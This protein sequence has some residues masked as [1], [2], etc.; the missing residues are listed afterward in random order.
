MPVMK[1]QFVNIV[2]PQEQFDAFILKH[3]LNHE[4]EVENALSVIEN[5]KGLTP[6]GEFNR[7][8]AIMSR[9]DSLNKTFKTKPHDIDIEKLIEN[10]TGITETAE[11]FAE[12]LEQYID[13]HKKRLDEKKIII[14]KNK[15]IL[16]RMM[17]MLDMEVDLSEL[18]MKFI[19]VRFGRMAYENYKRLNESIKRLN[20]IVYFIKREDDDVWFSYYAPNTVINEV[21]NIFASLYFERIDLSDAIVGTPKETAEILRAEIAVVENEVKEEAKRYEEFVENSIHQ[22]DEIYSYIYFLFKTMDIKKYAAHTEESFYLSG[23]IPK[24]SMNILETQYR[25]KGI[26]FYFEDADQMETLKSPTS[27]KNLKIIKPFEFIVK[28]YG[29]PSA[30]EI[31]PT[32]FV[33]ITYVL[34]FGMM[35]GDVGHGLIL[36]IVG[37]IIYFTKKMD[38]AGIGIM[39]GASSILFGFLY[40]S[41]FGNEEVLTPLYA[42]PMHNIMTMFI[43]SI[44]FG[45]VV[46]IIAM[47]IN[48]VNAV[49]SGK[50]KEI[51]FDRNG[52]TGM[53]FYFG[54]IIF[55]TVMLMTGKTITSYIFI[56]GFF[57][58]P[59]ILMF[60][61]EPL[62]NLL[63]GKKA[64]P[65]K[66]KGTFFVEA[67][68]EVFEALLSFLSNTLSFIRIGAFAL[69]HAGLSLAVWSVYRLIDG[70]IGGII[71][72]ILGNIL[73]IVLE[74]L[75]VGIQGMRLE[76]YE[77]FSRFFNGEGREFRPSK[78]SENNE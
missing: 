75:V 26:S 41:I 39:C 63:A 62:H 78:I 33:A 17:P 5:I 58:L 24:G 48:I 3:I 6:Y 43:A 11:V 50:F 59:I 19:S 65:E 57:I 46:I 14:E 27:L 16:N 66:E 2:G 53:V 21:D 76:Y 35:F 40:G 64:L 20:V 55:A 32:L 23:W 44:V 42:N 51:L 9:L 45:V 10:I 67:F 49:K 34:M 37:A 31:D 1:M 36:M 30:N 74:G 29:T 60:L 72:L 28:T 61:K 18:K 52:I 22:F 71:A 73:I 25:K 54:V 70:Q 38:I 15:N 69:S 47:S 4:F 68:F 56:I 7:H 12:Q 77:L 13:N 8:S